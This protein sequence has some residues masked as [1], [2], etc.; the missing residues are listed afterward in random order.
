MMW[1]GAGRCGWG[2]RRWLILLA[3]AGP[4]VDAEARGEVLGAAIRL[5]RRIIPTC[6][7]WANQRLSVGD[8]FLAPQVDHR[9]RVFRRG[10][11][12]RAV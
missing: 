4:M 7:S 9:H 2:S 3:V 8:G 11:Q 12:H 10:R 6:R 5:S 1:S